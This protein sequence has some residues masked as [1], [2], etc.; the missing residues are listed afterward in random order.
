MV[1]EFCG[2]QADLLART[3]RQAWFGCHDCHRTWKED[4]TRVAPEQQP[5]THGR[6]VAAGRLSLARGCT[7]AVAAVALAFAIR[8]AL[9][10]VMAD[11]SP[12]LL[13]TP[14]VMLAAFY[15]GLVPSI[16]AT[17]LSAL[18]GNH[19][20]LQALGEPGLER[21]DRVAL[22]VLVGGL[23]SWV[24][25][26][27]RQA[28]AQL[29][30]SLWREQVARAESEAANQAKD[31]FLALVS[32]ELQTPASVILGWSSIV[33]SQRL[34]GPALE[35]AVDTIE[36]NA[37]L[38]SKLIG[39]VLDT[40]RIVSGTLRI[41]RRVVDIGP[42]VAAAVEQVRPSADAHRLSIELAGPDG[43]CEVLG[44]PTRLQQV[45][46]N[47]LSNAVKFTPEGGT[48]RVATTRSAVDVRVVV[49]DTGVGID[50]EFLPR[51]FQRFEQDP[52]TLAH[53]RT[54]L[55]LG[56]SIARHFVERQNGTIA[57]ESA[58]RGQGSSFTVTLPLHHEH[59]RWAAPGGHVAQDALRAVSVLIV[60]DDDD[61][62][63]LVASVLERYGARVYAATSAETGRTLASELRPDVILCDL[64]LPAADGFALMRAIRT[65]GDERVASI[66][67]A[68][69]TA[70][71]QPEERD[72]ALAAGFQM[73]LQKPID[74]EELASVVLMLVGDSPAAPVVH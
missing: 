62:R 43:E 57:V 35:R 59:A 20:F 69:M 55:G 48:I 71:L 53:S 18:L 27:S 46:A 61:T 33:R 37:R 41:D 65:A 39:D 21:W 11:A 15:G 42:I 2:G 23:I 5:V 47:L 52:A 73:H 9:K 70:S 10:P 60:E 45:F 56:L 40:S 3:H 44:D 58:G 8:M 34:A 25:A 24:T 28:S 36:R 13:F 63:H 4:A 51:I 64:R 16:V 30:A 29:A 74:P 32:H 54:G 50:A 38:S 14:A 17:V 49:A 6:R 66:P 1:C 72:R 67:A 7:L 31:E 68:S 12:F 19:F 22:F 26:A